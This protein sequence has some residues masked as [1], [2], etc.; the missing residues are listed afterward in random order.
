MQIA[1]QQKLT[2]CFLDVSN[3]DFSK[4]CEYGS[5][6]SIIVLWT[7]IAIKVNDSINGF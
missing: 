3:D 6:L 2:R 7:L 1:S 4:T 5:T